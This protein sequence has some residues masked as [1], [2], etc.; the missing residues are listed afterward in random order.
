MNRVVKLDDGTFYRLLVATTEAVNNGIVHG[1]KRDP[2]KVVTVNCT[3]KKHMLLVKVEDQGRGFD[4]EKIPN[5]LDEEN[6]LKETGRGIFL[7]K[8]MMDRVRFRM[9]KHGTLVE[10]TINLK[11]L[12]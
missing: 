1:N 7:M 11:R 6:L 4:P 9:T 3:L 10:M 12:Q 2:E 5:P 8:S